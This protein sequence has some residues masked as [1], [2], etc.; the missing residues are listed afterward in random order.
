MRAVE[1][2]YDSAPDKSS[3]FFNILA[4]CLQ[5]C[6]SAEFNCRL[7]KSDCQFDPCAA[8]F[9]ILC[10]WTTTELNCRL[11]A[12]VEIDKVPGKIPISPIV[13]EPNNISVAL[14]FINHPK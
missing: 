10:P 12:I 3:Q 13:H 1:L 9:I 5:A 4:I 14:T 2:W 8:T 6:H 11:S 7:H